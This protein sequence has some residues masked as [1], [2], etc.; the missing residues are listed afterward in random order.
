MKVFA[1]IPAAGQGRR[2]GALKQYQTLG[3]KPL[4]LYAVET[5]EASPLIEGICLVVPETELVDTQTLLGRTSFRK[6]FKIV[7]GG[8]ERQD[9]VRRGFAVLPVCNTVVVHD[10][11][12]PFISRE[13]IEKTICAAE[14]FGGAVVGIP[15]RETTKR[16]DGDLFV[17]ETVDRS[18]LWSIQTPQAFRYEVFA[19][20]LRKAEED[21]F[22]G[23]DESMLVERTGTKVKV[24]EGSPYNIKVTTPED[25]QVAEEILKVWEK[26]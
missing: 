23:T 26:R 16:V 3:G 5:F 22:L 15:V 8:K 24:I 4:L 19:M 1:I 18:C 11:V 13:M 14:E 7:P 25:L 9:S 21:R 10:G 6:V 2:F 20:A 17:Q 12:R